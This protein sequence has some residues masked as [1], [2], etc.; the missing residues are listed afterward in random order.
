MI[1]PPKVKMNS[2]RQ[3]SLFQ[4]K[5]KKVN[6]STTIVKG[7]EESFNNHRENEGVSSAGVSRSSWG[8]GGE[9][10]SFL[11]TFILKS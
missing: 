7:D 2:Q 6:R 10:E 3:R 5:H 1:V 4:F 8:K 9:G 11:P